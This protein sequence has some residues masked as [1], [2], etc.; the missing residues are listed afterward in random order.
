[1]DKAQCLTKLSTPPCKVEDYYVCSSSPSLKQAFQ[2]EIEA[3]SSKTV[4]IPVM[5]IG[6]NNLEEKMATMKAMLE[7]LVKESKEKEV[8]SSCKRKRSPG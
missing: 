3:E 6:T 1:M 2:S 7:W 5:R 4:V 8:A